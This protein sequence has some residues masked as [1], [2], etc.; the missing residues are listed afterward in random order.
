MG[1]LVRAAAAR[2]N[3]PVIYPS[4][5]QLAADVARHYDE[6]DVAYRRIWGEHVHHGYW[7]TGRE[8]PAEAAAALAELVAERLAP[9]PGNRVVDIGCGYGATAAW[10]AAHRQ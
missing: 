4:Q 9:E 8:S 5:P 1:A 6:L 2:H 7:R 10:L 3:S